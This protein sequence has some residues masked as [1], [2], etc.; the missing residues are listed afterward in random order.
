MRLLHEL[1][2]TEVGDLFDDCEVAVLPTGA[3]EQ[4][5][6]ALPLGTDLLAA[7]AV[8]RG[9]DRDD[10]VLLPTVPVGVSA[11]HRQFDGTLWAEPETFEAYVGEIVASVAAHG[12]RKVVVANG[13][14]GNRDALSRMARRLRDDGVAFAPQW[15]WWSSL[16]GLDEELFDRSGIGHGDAMETSMVRHVAADL[17]REAALDDAEAG[18]A[19]SWGES[20]HG[21]SVGFDTAE[22]SASGVTGA[23]TEASAEAGRRL[24]E[25][26]T[27]E[28]D[29]LV[30]WLSERPFDALTP[31]PH[32]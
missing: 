15:T 18:A 21:A 7:E 24:Y 12:V 9:V 6:P 4:H 3:V 11:H 28:L 22:F 19:D 1:T 14:G 8:A 5:G 32:R 20:V 10:A 26:A 30:G 17:V 16:D 29:A 27:D 2:T 25:R 23:P 31:E 13:H